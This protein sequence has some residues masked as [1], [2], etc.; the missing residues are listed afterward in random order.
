MRHP[1]APK[2]GQREARLGEIEAQNSVPPHRFSSIAATS[3][4][5]GTRSPTQ[6]AQECWVSLSAVSVSPPRPKHHRR[7]QP[8]GNRVPCRPAS[9][10]IDGLAPP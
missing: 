2:F 4:P 3:M 10:E 8:D 6:P 9:A 7:A 5:S 1:A